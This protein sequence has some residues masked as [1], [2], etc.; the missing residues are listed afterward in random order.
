MKIVHI[1]TRLIT[2]GAQENTLIT[3][4]ELAKRGHDVTLITGPAFGPEGSLFDKTKD[5]GYKVIT[6]SNLVRQINPLKDFI[7]YRQMKKILS[8]IG[9]DIV[10][11]HSAKAGILGRL[12]GFRLKQKSPNNK[13]K[14]IHTIHGLAFHPYQSKLI[15]RLYIAI[16]RLAAGWS[17]SILTVADA[18][19]RQSLAADIGKAS[20]YTTAYSAID[21]DLFIRQPSDDQL[22]SF[23]QHHNIPP[24]A[25]VFVTVARLFELKG[26]NYIIDSAKRLAKIFPNAIWLFVGDGNLTDHYK[27]QI[28]SLGLSDRFRFTGL[29]SPE[30]VPLAIWSSDILVHCS[31]REGLARALVQAMLCSKPVISFDIDGAC[32]VVNE[33]TGRLI[34]P[35][36]MNQLYD[37]CKELAMAKTLRVA[38]GNSGKESVRAKF[39]PSTMVLAIESVYSAQS[40]H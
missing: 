22:A 34:E 5:Q 39:S 24:D 18:M 30:A 31:L 10:H 36:N 19:T 33:S 6:I 13:P 8:D 27:K 29:L 14:V 23:R 2:G 15:N 1:I 25:I 38:L 28:E 16:E 4:R 37:S 20:L 12:A 26:H 40:P 35:E 11:S 7:A 32:E 9:P 3:C 21:E 17:D